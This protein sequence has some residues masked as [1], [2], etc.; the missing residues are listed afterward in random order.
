MDK[1][2]DST[3]TSKHAKL[4]DSYGYGIK[5]DNVI[6]TK[7]V[8]V[9]D[10]DKFLEERLEILSKELGVQKEKIVYVP[11]WREKVFVDEVYYT[12]IDGAAVG[13]IVLPTSV[14]DVQAKRKYYEK[15][16]EKNLSIKDLDAIVL[17]AITITNDNY[18]VMGV[19]GGF[20]GSGKL[21]TCPMGHLEYNIEGNLL[22][23]NFYSELRDELG[24]EEDSVKDVVLIGR[25]VAYDFTF[26]HH[27]ILKADVNQS[28]KDINKINQEG[29]E[30]YKKEREKRG[31]EEARKALV[32]GPYLTD[33]WEHEGGLIKVK[34][35]HLAIQEFIKENKERILPVSIVALQLYAKQF[36]G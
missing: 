3:E 22:F 21:N 28:F 9:S 2:L 1:S 24:L 13:S 4:E 15:A 20:V 12:L 5:E 34:N 6:F 36:L 23:S 27:Y 31:D 19:R 32:E 10:E 30:F 11:R 17:E 35:D 16:R 14:Y 26:S 7:N 25:Q 18:I 33:A 29:V 8:T